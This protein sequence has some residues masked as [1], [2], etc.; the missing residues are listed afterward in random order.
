MRL[1]SRYSVVLFGFCLAVSLCCGC[2]KRVKR[3]RVE[4]PDYSS[5]IS[6]AIAGDPKAVAYLFRNHS[7]G[8]RPWRELGDSVVHLA[9]RATNSVLLSRLIAAG[10]P[11]NVLNVSV[12]SPLT[13]AVE[14]GDIGMCR[15][16]LSS[17]ADPNFPPSELSPLRLAVMGDYEQANLRLWGKPLTNPNA[18]RVFDQILELLISYG[19][20]VNTVSKYTGT[21]LNLARSRDRTTAVEILL[22]HGAKE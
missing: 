6:K 18:N 8:G 10:A 14:V 22:R 11:L 21:P 20:D 12:Q 4:S 17:G 1:L 15:I 9:V 5:V 13:V 7:S 3:P 19:A 16:L 2:L